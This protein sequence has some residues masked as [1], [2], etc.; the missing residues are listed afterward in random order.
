MLAFCLFFS[1]QAFAQTIV[2]GAIAV[3]TQ[4]QAASGPYVLRGDVVVQGGATLHIAAGTQI[5]ME[6]NA[7]LRVQAGRVQAIGTAAEPIHVQSDRVRIGSS[8]QPGDWGQWVFTAGTADTLLEHVVFSH[9]RGVAVHGSAPV[10]NHVSIENQ[11]GAAVS[12]DL[13]ASPSGVGNAAT[14]NTLNGI[15]V[16]EGDITS[17]VRWGLRGIPYVVQNGTV[18]VGAS[19][20]INSIS[21]AQIQQGETA[22]Y[23]FQGTRLTGLNTLSF[24]NPG[25]AAVAVPGGSAVEAQFDITASADAPLGAAAF[26]AL[27]DAGPAKASA[28][29]TVAQAQPTL[30]TLTPA[31]LFTGQGDVEV[32]VSGRGFLPTSQARV[33]GSGVTTRFV[34][35]TEVVATIAAPASASVLSVSLQTPDPAAPGEFLVS[36]AVDLPVEA[37]RIV[38]SPSSA[39]VARG[40]SRSFTVRLPYIAPSDGV[41]VALVSSVPSVATVAANVLVPAGQMEAEVPVSA[42]GLGVTTLTASKVG[43]ISGQ[44]S[45]TVVQPPTL[46]LTPSVLSIGQGRNTALALQSSVAAGEGGLVVAVS[47]TDS[48]VVSVPAEVTIPAGSRNATV[49]ISTG[50]LGEATV[51]ANATE[52]IGGISTISVRP[53]SVLLPE[54]LLVAPGL[55]RSLPLTLSDPA[56]AGGLLVSLQSSHPAIAGV[57]ASV[58]VPEG[59]TVVNFQLSGIAAGN[60]TITATAN[61]YQTGSAPVVVE[62]INIGIGS[63]AL[64]SVSVPAELTHSYTLTLSRPAPKGGVTVALS[65]ADPSIA[66]VS[67]SSIVIAEGEI[68]GNAI[69]VSVT[70]LVKGSTSL[71][72]DAPGLATANVPVTVTGKLVLRVLN[73]NNQTTTAAGKGM[74]SYQNE[75]YV[76]LKTD[77]VNYLAVQQ[78]GLAINLTSSDTSKLL[79]PTEV[80]VP[81]NSYY[82]Y[83][84]ITGV[85]LTSGSPVTVDASAEGV[86]SPTTKLSVNVVAP[87]VAFESLDGNRAPG[88]ARDNFRLYVRVPGAAYSGNETVAS[89]M[90]F[91]LSLVEAA[92]ANVVD[93]FYAA[94][95]GGNTISQV[96]VPAGNNRSSYVHVGSPTTAGSYKVRASAAGI[97]EATSA[98]Q[99]VSAP[100]L[101]IRNANNQFTAV[102]G[103]GMRSYLYEVHVQRIANGQAFNGAEPLVV[104]LTSSDSGKV[105]VPANVTIPA[106][107]DSVNFY[108]TGVGLTDGTP[109]TI[110]AS[111]EGVSSPTTKLS[112]NVVAPTVA[113]ESLDG[114]RAPGSARDNFRLYV[115]VPGAAY[116]GNETVASEMPF[117]LSLVEAAPANVVDGFYAALTGGNTISQVVV[118]AGNNRSSYVHVGSPTTAGSYKVRASAAGITEAT[119]AVQT[120][121]AP[122][123]RIRNANN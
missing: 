62:T 89:E 52:Y 64:A 24:E 14:G 74:R 101:R 4:W 117:Q 27:T 18:S 119:S 5:F 33:N 63:P 43:F 92:P 46:T 75:A 51:S 97:T 12:V 57:P 15:A 71:V 6:A 9:G 48:A 39:T 16:P 87:T 96:V 111:A 105:S 7:G 25:I 106:N 45:I 88:S 100:E 49:A 10:F 73:A 84:A 47:S 68:T 19:P 23:T 102:V 103:K 70:G 120:V 60:A 122:E 72:A 34:S 29:L 107:S 28:T 82:G 80:I 37:A 44:S 81:A 61:G 31:K 90:P 91:Q 112:V 104:N 79:V 93:G 38:L 58:T 59:E 32:T 65:T 40:F 50:T 109:V 67:P 1:A 2:Q 17:S 26:Q 98:V 76:D 78:N 20:T 114:N 21:P 55:T 118:P 8:P 121:S 108:V 110:D 116:S 69:K 3:D 113:F 56:P 95:T 123:L 83:F 22:T 13:A 36:N 54:G 66:T 35:A 11:L 30:T 42:V 99:T 77:G 85:D 115:R 94:L 86:S 53:A 41:T